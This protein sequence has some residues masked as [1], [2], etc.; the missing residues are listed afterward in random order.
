MVYMPGGA[1]PDAG[2]R[3]EAPDVLVLP[4]LGLVVQ[5]VEH[6]G[7]AHAVAQQDDGG[8]AVGAVSVLDELLDLDKKLSVLV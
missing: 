2:Q 5:K 6:H 3:H 8:A 4:L 1:A 7:R